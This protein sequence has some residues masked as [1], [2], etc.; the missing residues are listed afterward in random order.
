MVNSSSSHSL[1]IITSKPEDSE[2]LATA[3]STYGVNVRI[4]AALSP[5]S[6]KALLFKYHEIVPQKVISRIGSHNILNLHNGKLPEFRGLHAMSWMIQKGEKFGYLTLH[7]VGTKV[8]SGAIVAEYKFPISS[9]MDINDASELMNFGVFKWLPKEIY[10]W[11]E[12]PLKILRAKSE[13]LFPPYPRKFD[14]NFFD[15]T[16]SKQDAVNLLRAVNPPYG[17]GGI[18]V[19]G[20]MRYRVCLPVS[21]LSQ[22]F[23]N[24]KL[25]KDLML[26]LSDSVLPVQDLS[27]K[28]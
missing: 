16:W 17:P 9:E 10:T 15:S 27:N 18:Y 7:Q 4:S 13:K 2:E 3:I 6:Q 21:K 5:D 20:S 1:E 24:S 28:F 14:D 25:S 12:D 11:L 8:D 22:D 23:C 26:Q 19:D